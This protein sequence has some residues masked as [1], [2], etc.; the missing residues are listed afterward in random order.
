VGTGSSRKRSRF[1]VDARFQVAWVA[2]VVGVALALL[3]SLGGLYLQG[4][5]ESRRLVGINALSTGAGSA[6]ANA[7]DAEFDA[8]LSSRLEEEDAKTTAWLAG[9]A[10][11]LVVALV[12]LSLRLTFQVAGPARAVS[13][14]MK[15]LAEGDPDPVR[16]LRRGDQLRFLEDD[17]RNLASALSREAAADAEVLEEAAALLAERPGASADLSAR[18]KALAA[19]KRERVPKA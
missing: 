4:K 9:G 1:V 13:M 17:V 10:A 14:M 16:H 3:L 7:E 12:F 6:G 8:A 11:L 2:L 19:H 15:R 18:L 5:A